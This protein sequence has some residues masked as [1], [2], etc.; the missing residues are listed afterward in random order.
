MPP[1]TPGRLQG[2]DGHRAPP[3]GPRAGVAGAHGPSPRPP[4]RA[5]R[6]RLDTRL[7]RPRRPGLALDHRAYRARRALLA[8]RRGRRARR[9]AVKRPNLAVSGWRSDAAC[10]G[11]PTAWWFPAEADEVL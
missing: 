8:H 10:R 2:L 1:G 7:G 3:P 4:R 6:R 11:K 9:R 5:A